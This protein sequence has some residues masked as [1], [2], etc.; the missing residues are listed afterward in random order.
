MQILRYSY[1]VTC[2]EWLW[3]IIY[4][5]VVVKMWS[6]TSTA[7]KHKDKRFSFSLVIVFYFSLSL[8]I[9]SLEDNAFSLVLV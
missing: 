4:T 6:M 3:F 5:S 7:C 8:V 9:G 2:Y 1:N